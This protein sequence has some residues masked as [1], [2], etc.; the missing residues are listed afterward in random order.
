MLSRRAL[1]QF[2]RLSWQRQ[3]PFIPPNLS[4][5]YTEQLTFTTWGGSESLLSSSGDSD[6]GSTRTFS[7]NSNSSKTKWKAK[8]RP[9]RDYRQPAPRSLKAKKWFEKENDSMNSPVSDQLAFYIRKMKQDRA[10]GA[11]PDAEYLLR[12]ADY[13]TSASGT[14]EQRMLHRRMIS[15][16]FDTE[17]EKDAFFAEIEKLGKEISNYELEFGEDDI[18]PNE[19]ESDNKTLL[20]SDKEVMEQIESSADPRSQIPAGHDWSEIVVRMDRVQKVQRGGTMLRYRCLVIGGNARGVA[21]FGVGKASEPREATEAASRMCKRN[22]FFVDP[23]KNSG[24]THD[25]V[26]KHNSCIVRLRAV[27]RDR[28]LKGHPLIRSI[29]L[30][31]GITD[32]SAKSHG[33]RNIYNVVYATF[34]ALMKHRSIEEIARS[35]GKRYLNLDRAKRIELS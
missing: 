29:L 28:G 16:A 20:E 8:R 21:G 18:V 35:R 3:H 24:I 31:F 23:Y 11:A 34:K 12:F 17:E 15:E 25:L 9:P 27:S 5:L 10:R 33:N 1:G 26:G 4:S 22:I 7:S 6:G 30:Y 14:T 13:L 19:D 32:C 2:A